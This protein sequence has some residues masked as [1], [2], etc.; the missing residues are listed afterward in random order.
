MF[1]KKY[2]AVTFFLDARNQQKVEDEKGQIMLIDQQ[3]TNHFDLGQKR[4]GEV[5]AVLSA[6]T[7]KNKEVFIHFSDGIVWRYVGFKFIIS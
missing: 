4:T 3:Q 6:I 1:D 7:E 5:E 2:K